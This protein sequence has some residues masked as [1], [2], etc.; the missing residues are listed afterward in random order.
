MS[1]PI[2]IDPIDDG[3][4]DPTVIWHVAKAEWWMFYTNRRARHPGP[5]FDW[6]HGSAIGIATSKD[7][8]DWHY[9]GTVKGLDDPAH[10]GLNTHWAPEVIRDGD[11]YHMFLTYIPGAPS[12]FFHHARNI[13]HF[14]SPDLEAWQPLGMLKLRSDQVIDAAVAKCPDGLWRL[15]YKD[16][17]DGSSTWS[18]TS[19]DLLDWTLEGKVLP[20]KPDGNP[21]EGPN[22]FEMG[23]WWW[24]IVDEW[25]GQAIFR[26]SD[27]IHWTRQGRMLD[28]P[29]THA[30]DRRFARHADV[31]VCGDEAALF[32]FTHPGWAETKTP[33]PL[34][35]AE[36]RTVV[37][38]ARLTVQ[39][40]TLVAERDVEPFALV[41]PAA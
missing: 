20:G 22:V 39:D 23:G 13:Y 4:A 16:E 9:R 30:E 6:I 37:H 25:H 18:A 40:G 11:T 2:F 35:H 12:R 41:P 31:V 8:I 36:R 15:W 24:L 29:G 5:D 26:S 38:V 32:Y 34:T 14:V 21:H 27:A 1:R 17:G 10:P 3:A 33:A 19:N 7:G 28:D